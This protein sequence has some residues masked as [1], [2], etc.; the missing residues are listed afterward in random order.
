MYSKSRAFGIFQGDIIVRTALVAAI[1]DLRKNPWALDYVFSSLD[2]DD[3]TKNVYG[4]KEIDKAKEW[5]LTT[6]IPVVNS[7]RIDNIRLPCISVSLQEASEL[8][9]SL[10]DK[11]YDTEEIYSE[12]LPVL[13]GPFGALSYDPDT[14]EMLLP[15]ELVEAVIPNE[16][17]IIEDYAKNSFTVLKTDGA[18]V[19]IAPNNAINP[20]KL[21]LKSKY[22]QKVQLEAVNFRENYVI[23]CHSRGEPY[24]CLYL[25]SIVLFSL[26]RYRQQF[27]EERGFERT[28]LSGTDLRINDAFDAEVVFS[29]FVT[30]S[31]FVRQ[32]WPKNILNTVESV[33]VRDVKIGPKSNNVLLQ[34]EAWGWGEAA[35]QGIKVTAQLQIPEVKPTE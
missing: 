5:F 22:P 35:E 33:V 11:N 6:E 18:T 32:Y 14:G 20:S 27:L 3:L 7:L 23:G 34:E 28:S 1:N 12:V 31:G 21:W 25:Y 10:A 13:F 26:L 24:E 29:R 17:M 4:Q 19:W 30:L 2:K 8:E 15:P 16:G 9:N